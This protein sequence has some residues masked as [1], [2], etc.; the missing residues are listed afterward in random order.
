MHYTLDMDASLE[1]LPLIAGLIWAAGIERPSRTEKAPLFLSQALMEARKVGQEYVSSSIRS[2]VRGMLRHGKYKPSGRG[3]P[4]SEFLLQAALRGQFP[5]VNAPVDVNNFIS[6]ASG[7][8]GSI[9]DADLLGSNLL[10][11]R[12]KPGE[13][14]VFNSSGQLIDL[15]DLIVVCHNSNDEQQP[16]GNPVKD[17]METK[18]NM[19][20][21]NVV[22]VLYAPVDYPKDV[23]T[24][25]TD[26]YADLLSSHC[27]AE[28]ASYRIIRA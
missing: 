4:A 3:K 7:L 24:H 5:L 28:I 21:R 9:F 26:R 13:A 22:A 18:T 15:Q 12:G 25:W 20:T 14:Y 2:S 17:S 23:L 6:L 16:C 10:I 1:P 27:A 11:R 8:P 19:K